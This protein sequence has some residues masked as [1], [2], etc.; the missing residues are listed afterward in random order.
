[1]LEVHTLDARDNVMLDVTFAD[2]P[3]ASGEQ[4]RQAIAA[5]ASDAIEALQRRRIGYSDL[6][7]ALTPQVQ[8]KEIALFFDSSVMDGWYGGEAALAVLPHL[9][10]RGNHSILTGDVI[11]RDQDMVLR[12]LNQVGNWWRAAEIVNSN[13]LYCVYVNNLSSA[14]FEAL[15]A[16]LELV[17]AAVGYADCTF[18]SPLKNILSTCVGTRYV[19]LGP[20]FI[21]SHP[22]DSEIDTNE[23]AA[24]WPLEDF[25]YTCWSIDDLSYGLFLGYKIE[26]TWAPL[27][28]NDGHFSMAAATGIWRDPRTIPIS[29]EAAKLDYLAR[30]KAG[31]LSRAGL[32]GMSSEELAE[33]LQLRLAQSYIFSLRWNSELNYSNF[34]TAIEFDHE[35][36]QVRLRA[37]LKYENEELGL[38]TLYG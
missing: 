17:D 16:G 38:V 12:E 36:Q 11:W 8:R 22:F 21:S 20:R 23:N 19:K 26:N 5:A 25:G 28:F 31:S 3:E 1:M 29:V 10:R 9:D 33:Q 7:T 14:A 2:Q 35:G 30:E 18:G 15:V 37:A 24:G 6:R 27:A 4:M 32:A 13:Q 34:A